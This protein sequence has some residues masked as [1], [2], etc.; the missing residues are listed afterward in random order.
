[1]ASPNRQFSII[2]WGGGLSFLFVAIV[3]YTILSNLSLIVIG[4]LGYFVYK[5]RGQIQNKLKPIARKIEY[6]I[7][8]K[9]KK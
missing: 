7:E 9:I 1:M 8:Q 2:K 6:H 4:L 5:K 3:I